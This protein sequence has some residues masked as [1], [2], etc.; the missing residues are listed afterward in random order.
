MYDGSLKK[1]HRFSTEPGEEKLEARQ[2]TP[3]Q[4][5]IG[6]ATGDTLLYIKLTERPQ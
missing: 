5:P 3:W 6:G 1:T 4:I 2:R